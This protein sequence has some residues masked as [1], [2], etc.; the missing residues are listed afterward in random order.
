MVEIYYVVVCVS[1]IAWECDAFLPISKNTLVIL[2]AVDATDS[3]RP[4]MDNVC[5]KVTLQMT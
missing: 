1:A 2:S 3:G 4:S 5:S